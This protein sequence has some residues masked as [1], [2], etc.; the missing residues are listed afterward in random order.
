MSRIQAQKK[1]AVEIAV[2]DPEKS[3]SP[4]PQMK[5]CTVSEIKCIFWNLR[6]TKKV[7]NSTYTELLGM[8]CLV[9]NTCKSDQMAEKCHKN[10]KIEICKIADCLNECISYC[11]YPVMWHLAG[12]LAKKALECGLA[13]K[14]YIKTSLC[15]GS[16]VVC[17]YLNHGNVMES[18]QQLRSASDVMF[19]NFF[20]MLVSKF[21][22]SKEKASSLMRC[23]QLTHTHMHTHTAV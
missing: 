10:A 6:S 23:T 18:L 2:S 11:C 22:F 8:V 21:D 4:G 9:T 16:G 12:L 15:P 14:P 5:K 17:R 7:F 3:A 19:S 20:C 13:V 1:H